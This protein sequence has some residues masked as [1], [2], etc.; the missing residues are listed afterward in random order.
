MC[1][2][3]LVCT[4]HVHTQEHEDFELKKLFMCLLVTF[5][6]DPSALRVCWFNGSNSHNSVLYYCEGIV[7]VYG[8]TWAVLICNTQ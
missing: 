4:S 3:V 8:T 7:R 1:V 5:S 2:F 6:S